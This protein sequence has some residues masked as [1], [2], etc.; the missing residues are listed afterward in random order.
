MKHIEIGRMVR[1]VGSGVYN[2]EI[3][4]VEAYEQ[5]PLAEH[6]TIARVKL[7]SSVTCWVTATQLEEVNAVENNDIMNCIELQDAY[8]ALQED[9][10]VLQEEAAGLRL[11]NRD[12]LETS[13]TAEKNLALVYRINGEIATELEELK[14]TIERL[15]PAGSEFVG[16]TAK[17]LAWI[18]ERLES[19]GKI[20]AERNELRIKLAE[21]QD[22][23]KAIVQLL[24]DEMSKNKELRK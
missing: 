9:Y 19:T 4:I 18:A 23:H 2:G 17:Q 11:N 3:G 21:L 14:Q 20:A 10:E 6:I 5:L 13:V 15:A 24:K 12:W 1:I 7:V 16:D 22:N 8:Q